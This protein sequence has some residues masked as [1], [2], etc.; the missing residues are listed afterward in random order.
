MAES[1]KI[2]FEDFISE[3]V[4]ARLLSFITEVQTK[5]KSASADISAASSK[6][7]GG[8]SGGIKGIDQNKKDLE[9][10]IKANQKLEASHSKLAE[11]LATVRE[12]TNQVNAETRQQAK[13]N[14]VANDS[15]KAMEIELARLRN[16]Y[17]NLNQTQR[18]SAKVGG[19]V[20]KSINEQDLAVKNIR[21]SMGQHQLEVGNYAL[22]NSNL[23][24]KVIE[25]SRALSG[26]TG[27]LDILGRIV[28]INTDQLKALAEA[29]T[30]LREFSRDLSH[31][32]TEEAAAHEANTVAVEAE[33]VATEEAA[34][35][36]GLS[37]GGIL[38][39]V[40][41]V[42]AAGVA[43]YEYINST[44][45]ARIAQEGYSLSI[46]GTII[47]DDKLREAHN[48]HIIKLR[49]LEDEYKVLMGTMSKYQSE[50]N[51]IKNKEEEDSVNSSNA[52]K[53][54][55]AESQHW[56]NT[57][58]ENLQAKTAIEE[59][60]ASEDVDR[61]SEVDKELRNKQ[62][63]HDDEVL[64]EM[65]EVSK[66]MIEKEKEAA[67]KRLE[68]L[69]TESEERLRIIREEMESRTEL[70]KINEKEAKDKKTASD[71]AFDEQI[72]K[73]TREA[74]RKENDAEKERAAD[75]KRAKEK[76]ETE[77][78]NEEEGLK[79]IGA[80]DEAANE[81]KKKG[82]QYEESLIQDSLTQQGNLAAAGNENTY[83][84]E[85]KEKAKNIADQKALDKKAAH[86]KEAL[87]LAELFMQFEIAYAKDS[88]GNPAGAAAKALAATIAAKAISAGLSGAFGE[89]GGVLGETLHEG[90]L[91]G[92]SHASGNDMLLMAEKG[93]GLVSVRDMQNLKYGILPSWMS[94]KMPVNNYS[95]IDNS[96]V[97]AKLDSLENTIR[98]KRELH[99]SRDQEGRNVITTIENGNI[100]VRTQV[101][102]PIIQ[103]H[104]YD[105]AN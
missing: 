13:L 34:I 76:K 55:I 11:K 68:V 97:V 95:T 62:A 19:Q 93:E 46:D 77:L 29:H 2:E 42:V 48:K 17:A 50:A 22:A 9:D 102:S 103:R 6:L 32:K 83:A 28:G 14:T 44:N 72:D 98:N 7:N 64:K 24:G 12:V 85:L 45:E 75:E 15:L 16:Q 26:M 96:E 67:K 25:S 49:E 92:K 66:K 88:S 81:R 91:A 38:L 1:N 69:K 60:Y 40:A 94:N 80:L 59:Q 73:D 3:D 90:S 47:L 105:R 57:Q 71:K 78:K 104:T 33:T 63:E 52:M 27:I 89:T 79:A 37:T 23:K 86:E 30:T 39:L 54:A 20:L 41:G 65:D 82:L 100:Q 4:A 58:R 10:L 61:Q 18:D 36:T 74:T 21:K 84:F 56:Y 87:Q 99:L 35:A 101:S 51:K 70:N 43:L 31:I 5:I 53:K 8:S